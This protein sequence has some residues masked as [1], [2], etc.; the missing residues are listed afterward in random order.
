MSK[1]F[2]LFLALLEIVPLPIPAD[3]PVSPQP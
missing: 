3:N 1:K 2:L